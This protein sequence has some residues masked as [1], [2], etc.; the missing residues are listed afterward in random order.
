MPHWV[1]ILSSLDSSWRV[2]VVFLSLVCIQCAKMRPSSPCNNSHEALFFF[3]HKLTL[4]YSVTSPQALI[5]SGVLLAASSFKQI[6]TVLL[7]AL[8][9]V[10]PLCLV[11]LIFPITF[12]QTLRQFLQ[13]KVGLTFAKRVCKL[14]NNLIF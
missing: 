9:G 11:F 2:V 10:V 4:K 13:V 6:A 1:T 3:L 14:Q 12:F 8:K 7:S 5:P